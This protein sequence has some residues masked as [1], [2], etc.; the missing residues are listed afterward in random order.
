MNIMLKNLE[1]VGGY[2][3]DRVLGMKISGPF[4][5]PDLHYDA[6]TA[7]LQD[8]QLFYG[9]GTNWNYAAPT[10]FFDGDL[11]VAPDF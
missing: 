8:R 2:H 9:N 4:G 11:A 5:G 10:L 6:N 1:D 7:D 3:A